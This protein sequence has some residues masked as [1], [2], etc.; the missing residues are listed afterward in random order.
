MILQRDVLPA[1][2]LGF[3]MVR[4]I[5]L[6]M[7]SPLLIPSA[8]KV[9]ERKQRVFTHGWDPSF[10]RYSALRILTPVRLRLILGKPTRLPIDDA[11]RRSR[12]FKLRLKRRKD[13]TCLLRWIM[14]VIHDALIKLATRRPWKMGHWRIGYRASSK[15]F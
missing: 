15:N 11:A 8:K 4:R 13:A 3:P 6:G 5:T 2:I 10:I 1:K 12:P 9:V 7:K 14:S